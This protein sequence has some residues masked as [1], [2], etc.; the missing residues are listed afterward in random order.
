M[1]NQQNRNERYEA[2]AAGAAAEKARQMNHRAPF[3]KRIC[4]QDEPLV[5]FDRKRAQAGKIPEVV[6]VP[7]V[8]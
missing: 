4:R 3:A 1:G 6:L 5:D 7:L 8:V 2:L